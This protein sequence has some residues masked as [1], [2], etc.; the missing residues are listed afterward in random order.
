M[1]NLF[2]LCGGN[3]KRLDNYSLPKPLNLINGKPM[4]YYTLS[5]IPDE[6]KT[7]NFIVNK[8]LQNYNFNE[9][10]INLFPTKKCNFYY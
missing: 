8:N 3:G 10:V 4:I 6:I 7:I 9:I 1:I 5:Q 2:V